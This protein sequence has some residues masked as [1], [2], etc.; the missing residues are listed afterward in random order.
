L[1]I[2]LWVQKNSQALIPW[3][4]APTVLVLVMMAAEALLEAVLGPQKNSKALIPWEL[5]PAVL[6]VVMMA[7]EVLLE[8]VLGS[9]PGE[10]HMQELTVSIL[11]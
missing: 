6:V 10:Q 2:L 5:A 1:L 8:V 7:V 11:A 9:A 4:L 3:E